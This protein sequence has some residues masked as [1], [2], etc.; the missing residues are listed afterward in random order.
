MCLVAKPLC[1]AAAQTTAM[2]QVG[3]YG[4]KSLSAVHADVYGALPTNEG[5]LRLVAYV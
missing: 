1:L 2:L 4:C 3:I 5:I